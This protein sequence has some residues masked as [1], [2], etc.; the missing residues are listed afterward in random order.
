MLNN[1]K[2]LA[3]L[4]AAGVSATASAG[5]FELFDKMPINGKLRTG[6]ELI[7]PGGQDGIGALK[8]TGNGNVAQYGYSYW[9]KVE[10]GKEYGMSFAYS[11]SA[12][13]GLKGNGAAVVMVNF[14]NAKKAVDGT[15]A[16]VA[17]DI[18]P[19]GQ[20]LEPAGSLSFDEAYEY[21]KELISKNVRK[22]E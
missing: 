15:S 12:R 22:T 13:L 3:A 6:A 1:K 8:I 18:G 10:P 7:K 5:M 16:L 14:A 2:L 21:F 19:I 4:L 17:L 11:A 9:F 20:L